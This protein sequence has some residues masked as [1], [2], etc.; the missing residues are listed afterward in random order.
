MAPRGEGGRADDTGPKQQHIPRAERPRKISDVARALRKLGGVDAKSARL[1]LASFTLQADET[2]SKS[3]GSVTKSVSFAESSSGSSGSRLGVSGVGG[4]Y[5]LRRRRGGGELLRPSASMTSLGGRGSA[6][7]SKETMKPPS[8]KPAQASRAWWETQTWATGNG[9]QS[10][11]QAWRI[12]RREL[13]L[14]PIASQPPD[15]GLSASLCRREPIFNRRTRE[16]VGTLASELGTT[17]SFVAQLVD[18]RQGCEQGRRRRTGGRRRRTHGPSATDDADDS[19]PRRGG[20]DAMEATQEE[21]EEEEEEDEE[22]GCD[23]AVPSV[24]TERG[25]SSSSSSSSSSVRQL[26]FVD[27]VERIRALLGLAPTLTLRQVV[28]AGCEQL[29]VL[30]HSASAI[31]TLKASAQVRRRCYT[32]A[33]GDN[34][35]VHHKN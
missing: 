18:R 25:A 20:A 9:R 6:K 23:A 21:E 27:A 16:Q 19:P 35:I 12:E 4:R 11:Q 22:V 28:E 29:G 13:K 34:G 5:D 17:E 24:D 15:P 3:G 31:S 2:R 33:G 32:G 7:P 1:A 10:S 8:V 26:R 14:R 30:P